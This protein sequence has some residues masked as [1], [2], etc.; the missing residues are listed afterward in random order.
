M[1]TQLNILC[2]ES[3]GAAAGV[4]LE[5]IHRM[6]VA[7]RRL[8]A[9]LTYFD[10]VLPVGIR[11]Q[12]QEQVRNVTLALGNSRDLDIQMQALRRFQLMREGDTLLDGLDELLTELE[13]QRSQSGSEVRTLIHIFKESSVVAGVHE[14]LEK[15]MVDP[16][17][18]PS[19]P[20]RLLADQAIHA[21]LRSLLSF[22]ELM[23]DPTKIEKLHAMRIAG[24]KLRY[25]LEI[26][27]SL[28]ANGFKPWLKRV[29][30][31]Q[32]VLGAIHDCD[33][34][35]VLLKALPVSDAGHPPG[36]QLWMENRANHR[37]RL[38]NGFIAAWD[39]PARGSGWNEL[40]LHLKTNHPA[41]F[42]HRITFGD[43]GRQ[44][45]VIQ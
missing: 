29:R 16:V 31:V 9:V 24:K 25:T 30:D 8:R 5:C 27:A 23:R 13:L 44:Q 11:Q 4:D 2:A 45:G 18:R 19:T 43:P 14:V 32:E 35:D 41:E 7:S 6:R 38:Y 34:W 36:I 3:D 15:W 28:D 10:P 22:T 42:T 12:F 17:G 26:F 40:E 20:L 39:S 21:R 1:L 33:A 37:R